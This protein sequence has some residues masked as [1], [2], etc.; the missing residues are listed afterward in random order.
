[1]CSKVAP[2][3]LIVNL[4]VLI[5]LLATACAS[6]EPHQG[7]LYL[8]DALQAQQAGEIDAARTM[9]ELAADDGRREREAL[10]LLAKLSR[11]QARSFE[12]AGE[13]RKAHDAFLAAAEREPR[14]T[15]RARDLRDALSSGDAAGLGPQDLLDVTLLALQDAPDDLSL[16]RQ[17]ARLAEE[18]GDDE[19]ALTQYLWLYSALPDDQRIALRLGIIFLS[20]DR[21]ADGAAVLQRIYNADPRNIQAA[22]NLSTA[23]QQLGRVEEVAELFEEL[24]ENFPEN[25]GI[26]LRYAAFEEERGYSG[27]AARLRRQAQETQPVIEEREMRPLR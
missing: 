18:L 27:R 7:D 10:E 13:H 4:M 8:K 19:L 2:H 24:V 21:P 11:D 14:R 16:H 9:A 1:M 26:L 23:Y 5:I 22:I 15:R 12:E 17:A 6:S 3:R 20:L 25:T